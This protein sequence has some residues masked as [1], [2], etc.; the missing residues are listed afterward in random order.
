MKNEGL[1]DGS[2]QNN[3]VPDTGI[4]TNT[5]P[6]PGSQIIRRYGTN[7]TGSGISVVCLLQYWLFRHQNPNAGFSSKEPVL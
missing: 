1:D 5:D 3:F 6:D 4:Q 7:P 2:M